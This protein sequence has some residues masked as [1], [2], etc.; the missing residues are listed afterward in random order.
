MHIQTIEVA[1]VGPLFNERFDLSPAGKNLVLGPNECGKSTLCGVIISI[2]YGFSTRREAQRSQTRGGGNRF[3]GTATITSG[4][5]TYIITR[6]FNSDQVVVTRK[7]AESDPQEIF[8]GDANPRG[9]TE[10]IKEYQRILREEIGFPS[11]GVLR[12]SAFVGQLD[13]DIQLDDELRRQISGAGQA[14]YKKAREVLREQY[15]HLTRY[16][17]PGDGA[18]RNDRKVEQLSEEISGLEF[19]YRRAIEDSA[20]LSRLREVVEES[21]ASLDQVSPEANRKRQDITSL[22]KYLDFAERYKSLQQQE[23]LQET[24]QKQVGKLKERVEYLA[25]EMKAERYIPFRELD[26]INLGLM[27]QYLN[28][29]AEETLSRIDQIQQEEVRLQAAISEERFNALREAPEDTGKQLSSL[30]IL[31]GDIEKL[32]QD[33]TAQGKKISTPERM[34]IWLIPTGLFVIAGVIGGIL[35]AVVASSLNFAALGGVLAGAGLLG[36]AAGLVGIM[37]AM[38]LRKKPGAKAPELIAAETRLE[39]TKKE[40]LAVKESVNAVL[41]SSGDRVTVDVLLER[42]ENLQTLRSALERQSREREVL[43]DRSILKTRENAILKNILEDAPSHVL[44]ERL[45]DYE[46]LAAEHKTNQETLDNL[47]QGSNDD[48]PGSGDLARQLRELLRQLSAIE[49]HYPTFQAFRDDPAAG[50]DRL[51]NSKRELSQ[52]A[53]RLDDLNDQVH[54]AEIAIAGFRRSSNVS[55]AWIEE[56]VDLKK[57]ELSRCQL[58]RDA[59]S[60]A[61]QT[62][63]DSIKEYEE[64]YLSRISSKTGEYFGLFTRDR[65]SG[66]E[67]ETGETI[68]VQAREGEIFDEDSLST[69]ARDQLYLALRLAIADLLS[70]ETQ[71]PLILDDSFVNFDKNRLTAALEAISKISAVRQ[72]VLLTHDAAYVDWADR[73]ITFDA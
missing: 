11:E 37:I 6:D 27:K 29:D 48:T 7:A 49:D 20:E 16:P 36:T 31:K 57:E 12:N 69:G 35:G 2:V 47:S 56:Q 4:M 72:V 62:L 41:E 64:E 21:K 68:K 34:S 3:E 52:L 63:D 60:I 19:E 33:V 43:E 38:W 40:L 70:D 71:L 59:L 23:L 17:L 5:F 44:K 30:R 51:E 18:R 22:G 55:P 1:G 8:N 66:V 14:D 32:E 58:Q 45:M 9:R 15:Y 26:A 53:S 67:I 10:E 61:I 24:Q 42:W 13:I 50:V 54:A 46:A 65:Y 25:A 73:V 28:S 39:D